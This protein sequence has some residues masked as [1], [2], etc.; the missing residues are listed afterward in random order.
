MPKAKTQEEKAAAKAAKEA[1]K[2]AK[3]SGKDTGAS[4]FAVFNANGDYVRTYTVEKHGEEAKAL[5]KQYA[6]KI[7]GTVK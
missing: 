1:A 6:D 3:V 2:T 4:E 5:A 7:G